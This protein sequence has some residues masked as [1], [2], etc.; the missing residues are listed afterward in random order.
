VRY[1]AWRVSRMSPICD[2]LRPNRIV[3]PVLTARN[4]PHNQLDA[5]AQMTNATAIAT[6]HGR[7][8]D[9]IFFRQSPDRSNSQRYRAA[10]R[11]RSPAPAPA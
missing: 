5:M 7:G 10:A 9:R 4:K 11:A 1:F 8:T 3:K 6:Q 2:S